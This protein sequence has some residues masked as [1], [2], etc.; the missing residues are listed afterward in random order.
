MDIDIDRWSED[1][2]MDEDLGGEHMHE[3]QQDRDSDEVMGDGDGTIDVDEGEEEEEEGIDMDPPTQA[4]PV[5]VAPAQTSIFSHPPS[6]GQDASSRTPELEMRAATPGLLDGEQRNLPQSSAVDD[7]SAA[8]EPQV[9]AH[10]PADSVVLNATYDQDVRQTD[11]N[12][13]ESNIGE[14]GKREHSEEVNDVLAADSTALK[15]GADHAL[16]RDAPVSIDDPTTDPVQ[17]DSV[18]TSS[19]TI[20]ASQPDSS[21]IK[22]ERIVPTSN[23]VYEDDGEYDDMQDYYD[24]EP[25]TPENL[26]SIILHLPE[27]PLPPSVSSAR[28]LFASVESDPGQIPVWLKNRQLEL[29][30]ASLADV[31]GAIRAE[32]AKEGLIQSAGDGLVITEKLMDLKMFEDDVNLQSITFLELMNLYHG[33]DLPEPVQLH[34]S[35]ESSRFIT[36]FS[37]IQSELEA[38][39][40]R[41]TSEE[42]VHDQEDQDY[43]EVKDHKEKKLESIGGDYD[44]EDED[45]YE[46]FGE[47]EAVY[48]DEPENIDGNVEDEST[49]KEDRQAA[50]D[51]HH[52]G[53]SRPSELPITN[54]KAA[55]SAA[56]RDDNENKDDLVEISNNSEADAGAIWPEESE[57][58]NPADGLLHE[59]PTAGLPQA[60][61]RNQADLIS[62]S[63]IDA[64]SMPGDAQ[65]DFGAEAEDDGS[66]YE[67]QV[68]L[69]PS[70]LSFDF[71]DKDSRVSKDVSSSMTHLSPKVLA[72]QNTLSSS[73]ISDDAG[74]VLFSEPDKSTLIVEQ[75]EQSRLSIVVEENNPE[76]AET[77]AKMEVMVEEA[78]KSVRHAG[79]GENDADHLSPK[80]Q[81]GN[82]VGVMG[83]KTEEVQI[84]QPKDALADV[85]VVPIEDEASNDVEYGAEEELVEAIGDDDEG[86]YETNEGTLD[87]D[88]E[89]KTIRASMPEETVVTP[90]LVV[91]DDGTTIAPKRSYDSEGE[92]GENKRTRKD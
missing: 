48:D 31:W 45:G 63:V 3:E 37:A 92:E 88:E 77:G 42:L 82:D 23:D 72:A 15:E 85:E 47:R 19:R 51:E 16:G 81:D 61:E 6:E 24:D 86:G 10:F 36:R 71:R 53:N 70:K 43:D 7:E 56:G 41:S 8:I 66:L 84:G 25:L 89:S 49:E 46:E 13:E 78:I 40:S 67:N 60:T 30:E 29:A 20:I 1:E 52:D 91:E 75:A 9:A 12:A 64:T 39:R 17:N 5:D 87:D 62:E 68:S 34:L 57:E 33:C 27:R 14:T 55:V 21:V 59:T 44:D 74:F 18:A 76:N 69:E 22:E 79:I 73:T 4:E 80:F 26:P 83:D 28:A 38:A 65:A 90:D 58:E 54:S 50:S 35:W 2:R 32:C 11:G